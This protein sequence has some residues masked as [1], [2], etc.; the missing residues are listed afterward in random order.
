M[1]EVSVSRLFKPGA[2]FAAVALTLLAGCSGD[3]GVVNSQSDE[4][5]GLAGRDS[6]SRP[7]PVDTE[8][9]QLRSTPNPDRNAYFGD[10]HIHTRYSFDAFVFGTIATPDDAYHYAKGH[11]LDHPSGYTMQLREPL[12]FY[13]VTDHAMFM[14]LVQESADTSSVFSSYAVA[15]PLHD[16][17]APDNM[18]QMS[19]PARSA[20]FSQFIPNTLNGLMDGEIDAEVA[21]AVTASAW[22]DSVRAADEAYIPGQFTTFAAYEYTTSSDDRGNL[23]RNV[24]FRDTDRLPA[25]P[26]SRLHSQNPEGLWDWMDGL[27]SQG[28]ESLAIPHNSNGSNGQMFKL[29]DWAGDPMDDDYTRQRLRNE[30]LVEITQVKGTSDTH[31]SLSKNDEWADFEIAPYRVAT[32]L[33]SEPKG[34]FVR[35]AYLNGLGLEQKGTFNPYRFGLVGAS[36]THTGAIS[37]DEETFSSKAGL[38]DGTAERRGSIPAGMISSVFANWFD[39]SILTEVDGRTYMQTSS[40]EYWSAS[41][42]AAVWA[43]ENNREAIYA[44]FRRKET[45]ATSGPRIKVRFFA[46]NEMGGSELDDA[47]LVRRAYDTGTA[48]GGDLTTGDESPTFLVWA[49][50]EV[51]R[52]PLQRLQVIKG[53]LENGEP[54]EQVYDVACSNGLQVDSGTHRCADNAAKVNMADCSVS[55]DVG[56]AELKTFWQDPDFDADTEAFYYVRAIENP[57]CR[58][59]TW[60]AIRAGEAPRSDLPATIQERA[61]SSPIWL[62]PDKQAA[63]DEGRGFHRYP[64]PDRS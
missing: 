63:E 40:F 41:G 4:E 57:S 49:V 11:P 36:D 13:A 43:E 26:F 14:G 58:W 6:G 33:P 42:L 55:A 24:I 45:F 2:M 9:L 39:P 54:M 1:S 28:I 23:H 35:E 59:S 22:R 19:I 29:V 21:R 3:S 62:R 25:I 46:S 7:L 15:E 48:M 44:A 18:G 56:A 64:G 52:T 12:D 38:L 17:N 16:I 37:Q 30:P 32:K 50:G 31:P 27:R 53:W 8:I 10:L 20:A 5:A 47:D 61:W 51:D 34:S 60:D